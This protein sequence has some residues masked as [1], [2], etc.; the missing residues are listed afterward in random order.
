MVL[1]FLERCGV[2]WFL[3]G[4]SFTRGVHEHSPGIAIVATAVADAHHVV[5]VAECLTEC[6]RRL[7]ALRLGTWASPYARPAPLI[8]GDLSSPL[9]TWK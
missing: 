6:W 7:T 4:W 1:P 3:A 5:D 9:D 2:V 8:Q